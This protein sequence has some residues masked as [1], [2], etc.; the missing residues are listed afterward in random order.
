[1]LYLTHQ[2]CALATA[3]IYVAARDKGVKMPECEW[4]EVFDCEREELGFLV[5]GMGSL[6][7]LARQAR[8]MW[9]EKGMITRADVRAELKQRDAGLENRNGNVSAMEDEE[10]EMAMMMDEKVGA[11]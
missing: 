11:V 10:A 4:W 5:V 8:E 1:M 2:P 3:A 6:E 9:G 7:G